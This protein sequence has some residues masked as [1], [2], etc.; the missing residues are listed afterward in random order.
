[1]CLLHNFKIGWQFFQNKNSNHYIWNKMKYFSVSK[2][3]GNMVM[4]SLE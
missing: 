1:M 3:D 2:Q 4:V